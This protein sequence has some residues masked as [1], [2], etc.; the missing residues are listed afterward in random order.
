VTL[1]RL[2]ERWPRVILWWLFVITVALYLE[3][4]R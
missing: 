1:L 3:H 4:I 2:L